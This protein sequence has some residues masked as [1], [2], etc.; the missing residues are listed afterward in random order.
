MLIRTVGL[1][2]ALFFGSYAAADV[3]T[4]TYLNLT[5]ASF[6]A[7]ASGLAFGNAVNVLATDNTNGHNMI[8]TAL[9]SGSTGTSFAF[10]PGPPLTADYLGAG[11]G[12]V[13]VKNGGTTFLSGSMSL[14]GH[15]EADYPNEAGGF[16]SRFIVNF[17]DPSI[18]T[19]LG[20]TTTVDPDG[21]IVLTFD[22]TAFNG[23]TLTG[24]LGG[25]S[26]TIETSAPVP[27]T[28]SIFLAITGLLVCGLYLKKKGGTADRTIAQC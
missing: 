3:V 22:Q 13:L 11:P 20:T 27:E 21:S 18:L 10:L 14:G 26:I 6:T 4:F 16:A 12:S 2:I 25:G 24:V 28:S 19:A 9:D 8:L 7:S 23:T 15:L 1:L 17:V 5:G